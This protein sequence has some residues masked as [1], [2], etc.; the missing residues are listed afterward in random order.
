MNQPIG[1][2]FHMSENV[3]TG[4]VLDYATAD[5]I[6]ALNLISYRDQLQKEL[7]DF[8]SGEYLHPED[9]AGNVK[10]IAALNLIISDF[11]SGE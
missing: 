8:S 11:D 7:D 2:R 4:L 1:W 9:V 10:R 3:T 6:T 5:R